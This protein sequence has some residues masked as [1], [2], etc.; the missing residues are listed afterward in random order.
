M[1]TQIKGVEIVEN[2]FPPEEG[3]ELAKTLL[4]SEVDWDEL[5]ID[6]KGLPASL[7]ISAFFNGFLAVISVER[8]ELFPKAQKICWEFDHDFQ[9]ENAARWMEGFERTIERERE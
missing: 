2:R 4:E 9:Y 5:E 8:P 6:L 7:L 1:T 3:A